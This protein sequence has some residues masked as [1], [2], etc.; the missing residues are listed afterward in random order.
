MKNNASIEELKEFS[1]NIIDYLAQ[2]K[3][4]ELSKSPSTMDNTEPSYVE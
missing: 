2:Y 4:G 3:S 1:K